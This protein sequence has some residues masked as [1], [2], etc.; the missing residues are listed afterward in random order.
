MS[1]TETVDPSTFQ[2]CNLE[3]PDGK[4]F[5]R[6]VI[7]DNSRLGYKE[8]WQV[9]AHTGTNWSLEFKRTVIPEI[10]ESERTITVRTTTVVSVDYKAGDKQSF[11]DS[12]P[13]YL[14]GCTGI[15]LS[16]YH[17]NTVCAILLHKNVRMWVSGHAGSTSSSQHGISFY[18]LK[19]STAE[20]YG[21]DVSVGHQ[22]VAVNGR[23]VCSGSVELQR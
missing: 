6:K 14:I 5:L 1:A 9:R 19:M 11:H 18:D 3:S 15:Y 7:R 17:M 20:L 22:T 12:K 10:G 23:V 8:C 21:G 16:S 2:M 13:V 4:K